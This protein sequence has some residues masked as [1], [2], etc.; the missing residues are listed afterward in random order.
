MARKKAATKARIG[1]K[2]AVRATLSHRAA[3]EAL[4]LELY[5]IIHAA[6]KQYGLSPL[7][8]KRFFTQSQRRSSIR[9]ASVEL[10][11]QIR[12]LG[13][14]MTSW[15]EEAPYVDSVGA[16][17]VLKIEGNGATFESLSKR[18]LPGVPVANVVSL[19]C[20]T[21]NVGT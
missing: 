9:H 20:R 21:A 1:S 15:S 8:Q 2:V 3:R 11:G 13:D 6:L 12:P 14:L 4:A 18:F 5:G 19:A 7:Q 17:R 16:P 10:L